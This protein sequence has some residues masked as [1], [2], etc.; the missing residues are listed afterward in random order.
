[1]NR[2]KQLR[3]DKGLTLQALAEL[4]GTD[5]SQIN[6]L[7]R[8]ERRLTTEWMER[9]AGALACTPADLLAN[10]SIPKPISDALHHT[11]R[12]FVFDALQKTGWST[13][14][15]AQKAKIAHIKIES[16]V[17]NMES[18][19]P[20]TDQEMWRI[21]ET[22]DISPLEPIFGQD[23]DIISSQSRLPAPPFSEKNLPVYGTS[24]VGTESLEIDF[25]DAQEYV[26]RPF[27][28]FSVQKGYAVFVNGF[29]MSPRYN[30]GEL[31][32]V[33]PSRPSKPGDYIIIKCKN[34]AAV[35]RQLDELSQDKIKVS[36]LNPHKTEE[37]AAKDIEFMHLIIGS[38]TYG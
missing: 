14:E 35:L 13:E 9:L 11:V 23:S 37:Y 20:L 12:G 28:L 10:T 15:L 4:V 34:E 32:H 24:K 3:K 22:A 7:E 1:M 6:R 29:S 16:L 27:N 5:K 21:A 18:T 2:I 26:E 31:L 17:H 33:N 38:V 19:V 30:H 36:T 25:D 8:G